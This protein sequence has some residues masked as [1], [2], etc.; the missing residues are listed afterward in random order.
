MTS[1]P[2][3]PDPYITGNERASG[4]TPQRPQQLSWGP[5]ANQV[6]GGRRGL[7]PISTSFNS[8]SQRG[9]SS[10]QSPRNPWSPSAAGTG[11]GTTVLTRS[12][13][14]SP[15]ISSSGSRFSPPNVSQ[16]TSQVG[17]NLRSITSGYSQSIPSTV[18]SHGTGLTG[19]TSGSASRL[20]RGSPSI[21]QSSV[22]VS[23]SVLANATAQT[24]NQTGSLSKIVVAQLVLLLST[25]KED[26]DRAK[27]ESQV[28]QIRKVFNSYCEPEVVLTCIAG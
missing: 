18:T 25:I 15:S 12:V 13:G 16:A 4:P 19:G 17:S 8:N 26:K 7:T 2:K 6:Q 11:S 27:W 10:S 9:G 21:S 14:R 3:P 23:S 20:S 28:D 24:G 5:P 22:L 1:S